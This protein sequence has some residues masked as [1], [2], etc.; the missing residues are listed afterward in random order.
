M[1]K[2]CVGVL[3]A[4]SLV[5]TPLLSLLA[6]SGHT[7]I[8]F[9]RRPQPNGAVPTRWLRLQDSG[10]IAEP[11]T[12]SV[13]HW[14]S[15]VPIWILP[16]L[17][18][19]LEMT[20][21]KRVIALSSTSVIA[22]LVSPDAGERALAARLATAE[23][24]VKAWADQR[25]V[26]WIILRPTMIYGFGRDRNICDI[27]RLICRFGFFPLIGQG[28]G[29]RQPIHARDVAEACINALAAGTVATGQTY[30]LSGGEI[31][32]FREMVSRVFDALELPRRFIAAPRP[33]V[34][35]AAAALHLLP[36]FRH[37]SPAAFERMAI[38]LVFDHS[39]AANSLSFSPQPFR[40]DQT[41]LPKTR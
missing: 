40:V 32:T 13:E 17:L 16:T 4:T 34:L 24:Q 18:K 11:I 15:A 9:S 41:D 19:L 2:R 10:D 1:Y 12:H 27:A 37:L 30:N 21:A 25:G 38:D 29:R 28:L 33:L 6:T 22:K 20:G 35:V 5:G 23:N 36:R 26:E 3:G 31:V 14:V 7:T 8:A 39:A